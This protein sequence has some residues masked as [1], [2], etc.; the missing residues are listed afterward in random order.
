[1]KLTVAGRNIEITDGIRGHLQ[2]KMEKTIQELSEEADV[3]VSLSTEIE[4]KVSSIFSDRSFF[5]ILESMLQSI[6]I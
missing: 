5:N 3:H 4:L 1:M 6:N 2:S